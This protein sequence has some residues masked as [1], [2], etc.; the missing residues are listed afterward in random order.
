MNIEQLFKYYLKDVLATTSKDNH[1][2]NFMNAKVLLYFFNDKQIFNTDTLSRET[3]YDLVE[4]LRYSRNNC[5]HSCNKKIG[6]L[7]RALKFND[8][9]IPGVS[10]FKK[11]RFEEKHFNPVPTSDL[12]KV[13]T[14]LETLDTSPVNLTR[15][16]IFKILLYT[17]CRANE[18]TNIKIS[19]VDLEL[20]MIKLERTKSKKPRYVV[21]D[22]S[23]QDRLIK[24]INLSDREYLFYNFRSNNR[25][26]AR[27]LRS[28]FD[29]TKLKFHLK[30]LHPHMLRHTMGT[31]LYENGANDI[32][33]AEYLGH[34]D[35]KT[36]RIYVHMSKI[37]N[38]ITFKDHFPKL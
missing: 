32:A 27:H 12:S 13:L 10:D 18:L 15:Y 4:Y 38:K 11:M 35:I 36:T 26:N 23:I 22:E 16:L 28:F 6:T 19:N 3:I 31:L 20:N 33:I 21:Y 2:H 30:E 9:F 8:I 1:H 17:G 25:Y 34:Q 37:S 5:I 29:Y 24:Y 7:K 14:Y